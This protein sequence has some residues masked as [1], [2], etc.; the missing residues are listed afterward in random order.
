METVV[1]LAM[2]VSLSIA[3]IAFIAANSLRRNVRRVELSLLECATRGRITQLE[4]DTLSNKVNKPKAKRGR[5]R[6]NV[7]PKVIHQLGEL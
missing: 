2:F 6:K 3:F 4:L 5:P 7:Q 1:G